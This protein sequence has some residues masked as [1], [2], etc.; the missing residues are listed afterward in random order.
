M[1]QCQSVSFRW[2]AWSFGRRWQG[3]LLSLLWSWAAYMRCC[4]SH[5]QVDLA[6]VGPEHK[7]LSR[8]S[9]A[10]VSRELSMANAMQRA[11]A[12]KGSEE[13]PSE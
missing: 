9:P 7:G 10:R 5:G 1:P 11:R 8:S 12:K 4:R 3:Q 13:G 2:L 6:V